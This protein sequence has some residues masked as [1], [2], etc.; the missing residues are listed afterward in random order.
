MKAVI[1]SCDEGS[2]LRPLTCCVPKSMLPIIGRPVI[3][4]TARLLNRHNVHNITIASN[5]LSDEIKKHFS[6]LKLNGAVIDF[7]SMQNLESFFD[8]DTIVISDSIITDINIEELISF[9]KTHGSSATLVTSSKL[10]SYEYGSMHSGEKHQLISYTQSPDF[11]HPTGFPFCGIAL[12]SKGIKAPDCCDLISLAKHLSEN[13]ENV[14]CFNTE[15]YI[16]DISDFDAYQKCIRDFFD[17]KI[18]LPF[19]CDEKAPSVW[20]DENAT[21]MQGAVIVPPVYIGSG[22]FVSKGARIE[23]YTQI[24]NDVNIDCYSSIKRS[25]IMDNSCIMEGCS[26]RGA[27]IGKNCMLGEESAAYEG[28]IIGS[29]AKVGKRCIIR[30]SV[31]IWPDKCIEDESC[32]SK[33]IIWEN[34]SPRSLFHSGTAAGIINREITP[35]F[36]TVL[37]RSAVSLL[38]KKIAVSS[39]GN[40]G[41]AMIKNALIAGI[42]SGGGIAYDF[43]DQPLPITR[44]AIRFH[45]LCGGIALSS[46]IRNSQQYA[47]LDIINS[48]G[49]DLENADMEKLESLVSSENAR[50]VSATHICE[51]EFMFE[52]KLYY[53]KQLINST[54]KKPLGARILLHCPSPWAKELLKSAA[55][56]LDCS[57]TFY[58]EYDSE[59]FARQVKDGN[60]D[61]GAVCDYKCETLSLITKSGK[62]LSEFDYCALTSLIIMKS[63]PNASVYVSQSAPESIEELAKKYNARVYRTKVSPPYL[64]NELSKSDR[65]LFMHQFI[66]RFDAVGAIILLIDYL[67]TNKISLELLLGEIP[68]SHIVSASVS[69]SFEEQSELLQRLFLRHHLRPDSASDAVKINFE[70]GWVIVVPKR[71][72]SVIQL[73]SHGYSKEYAEELADICIDDITRR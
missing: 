8:D 2:K 57:F 39:D 62:I 10:K 20:I 35:E 24:C 44:S 12:L 64:M 36:A 49:A 58:D 60:Y 37:G 50:R 53:L 40:S 6:F 31:H 13:E 72:E 65:K 46:Y 1:I 45:S 22:S 4:H 71:N 21:V 63:Y 41:G 67:Y 27:I 18:S 42:Q 55:S 26:I 14:Y 59:L 29:G 7:I 52:Y 33:N 11:M 56:D 48:L 23:S 47:S 51:A 54:S 16:K 61:M 25:T 9:H 69:C 19:P 3:E 38:G 30:T 17:K 68:P 34:S 28:S 5:Y 66:Y 15:S 43:G 32:I 70:N 73:I